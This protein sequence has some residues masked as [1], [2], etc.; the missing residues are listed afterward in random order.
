MTACRLRLGSLVW[1]CV[2]VGGLALGGVSAGAAVRHDYLSQITEVP[3]SSGASLPGPVSSLDSMTVDSGHLWV[4]EHISGTANTR[5]DEFDA[6]SGAFVLQLPQVSGITNTSEGVAVGHATGEAQ[7]YVGAASAGSTGV[8]TVFSEA[9]AVLGTPWTGSDTPGGSFGPFGVADVAVD[10][11]VTDPAAGDVYVAGGENH[12]VVYVFKPEAGGKEKYVTQLTGISE[13]EHFTNPVHV[14]VDGSTGDVLVLDRTVSGFAVDVFEPELLGGYRFVRQL[15]PPSGSYVEVK[16]IAVDASSGETYVATRSAVDQFSS[17]GVYV[18]SITGEGTPGGDLRALQSVAVDP[19]L[20]NHVYVGDYREDPTGGVPP[21]PSVIDV[22]GGD[23]VVPDV[24]TGPLMAVS[25]RSATLTGTVN[26]DKVGAATCRFVWGTSTEFGQTAPC[27]EAVAEGSAVVAVQASLSGLEAD[28]AYCYR[29]QATNGNGTNPGDSSQDQCFTTSGPGL[30]GESVSAV[31]A[32]SVT[33]DATINPHNVP[34]TYYFQYGTTSAYGTNVPAAPGALVGSGE[35]DQ[36]VSQHVQGREANTVYHYRVVVLSEPVPGRFEEF[37]G[38]DQTFTTQRTGGAPA[39]PDGRSWEMVT[40]PQKYGALFLQLDSP[41]VG[42]GLDVQASA[43]GSAIADMASQPTE[44]EPQGNSNGAM[45]LSTRGPAGWTSQVIAPSNNEGTGPAIG[46]GNEY[47]FF[48]E[49]LSRGIV[50]PLGP[51]PLSPEASESTAYVHTDYVN[52]NV[53]EHCQTSC[54]TPLVTAANTPSGTVFGEQHNGECNA[55]PQCG[56]HFVGASPDASHIVLSSP[57]QLTSVP[58]PAGGGLYEWVAGRLQLVSVLPED[59]GGGR[60]AFKSTLGNSDLSARHA[61]S[62]DGSRVFW[63]GST[64]AHTVGVP[65]H[66]HLYMRDTARSET[67]R[68]DL[69]QGVAE[70]G[71]A[72]PEYMTASGDGSRVFF[73]DAQRLTAVASPA[74]SDLYEYDLAAPLGS[75]LTDLTVAGKAGEAANV[76]NVL[77]ASE[78]G[79]YVYFAAGGELAPNARHGDCPGNNAPPDPGDVEACNLYVRHAGTTTLVAVL[80]A[81]DRPD[82]EAGDDGPTSRVSP[83]GRWLAFMSNRSM[84][85]YDTRDAFSGKPD[86]EVYL[87][88]AITGKLTCASCNPTGARPVGISYSIAGEELVGAGGRVFQK[89]VWIASNIPPWTNMGTS[90]SRYQSR[91]LSDSGRLFFD[92]NDALVPQDVNGTQDVYEYEQA[93][94]GDCHMSSVSFSGRSGGCVGLISSGDSAEESAFLEASETGGDVFFL[95]KAKLALQDFDNALDVYDAHEC[96][97][98][99]PCFVSPPVVPPPCSTGDSCKAS[100][101]PQPSIFGPSSSATFSGAGNVV[102]S[103][104]IS[105]VISKSLTRGQKLVRALRACRKKSG[106]GKRAVCE[107]KARRRYGAG[108]SRKANSKGGGR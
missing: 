57:V 55:P 104:P 78:D 22:F 92:S 15:S 30:H 1:L 106:V 4:A 76:V 8:V 93:G 61:I 59:E 77:G 70:T 19:A 49:D 73:L 43:M 20:P 51:T 31:T 74:G 75:R 39:L 56:P 58:T 66:L 60:A 33:L 54:F 87:Y 62:D 80:S 64:K 101:S 108:K 85:G 83:D 96:G 89:G 65:V 50:Q 37:D 34:T 79:S 29:L 82:W 12:K 46:I 69:P 3:V 2:L 103:G 6:L 5:V 26:P 9:G 21:Q 25:P 100:P 68:L 36:E 84:T 16:N 10:S 35:G 38:P 105:V 98:Q 14:A 94:V 23:L 44:A 107:R 45:V 41:D 95:T 11:S 102:P 63:E 18:G 47:R 81:D 72:E 27:S 88:D 53:D 97:V 86:E 32:E 99:A 7:V 52:G 71:S 17:A 24:T 28:T 13:E 67:V 90:M 48:S 40:P 91:Y 42:E